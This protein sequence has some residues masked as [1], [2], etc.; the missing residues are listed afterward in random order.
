MNGF[1][2]QKIK[3]KTF[4]HFL[5]DKINNKGVRNFLSERALVLAQL[6]E[7]SL[8][9]DFFYENTLPKLRLRHGSYQQVPME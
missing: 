5:F 1:R 8:S 2:L 6:V 7:Q 9:I 3:S 4:I